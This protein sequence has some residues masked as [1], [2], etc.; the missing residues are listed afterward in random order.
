[1]KVSGF[2][3]KFLEVSKWFDG[4]DRLKTIFKS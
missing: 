3:A 4:C 1:M 2:R